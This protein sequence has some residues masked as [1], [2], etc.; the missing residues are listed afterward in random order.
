M[1]ADND[2]RGHSPKEKRA[3]TLTYRQG[4]NKIP[5]TNKQ[6]NKK[7]KNR[8]LITV[9]S[10]CQ[11]HAGSQQVMSCLLSQAK[12]DKNV[13]TAITPALFIHHLLRFDFH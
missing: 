3:S 1:E 13:S 5:P 2:L 10:A 9:K 11:C 12:A 4:N 7:N 8:R 6:K